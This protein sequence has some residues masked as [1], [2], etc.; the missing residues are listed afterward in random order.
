MH[1]HQVHAREMHAHE[2][3][4]CEAH[5]YEVHALEMHVRKVGI[6]YLTN[7]CAVVDLSRSE[8]ENTSFCA[9]CGVVPTVSENQSCHPALYTLQVPSALLDVAIVRRDLQ[10]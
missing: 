5:T 8:F 1:A 3:H 10:V 4:T 7:G 9:S 6:S 2:V